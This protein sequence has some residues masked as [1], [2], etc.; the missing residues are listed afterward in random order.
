MGQRNLTPTHH[1]VR[2][3]LTSVKHAQCANV[4]TPFVSFDGFRPVVKQRYLNCLR[5]QDIKTKLHFGSYVID[6]TLRTAGGIDDITVTS[7]I[8]PQ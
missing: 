5:G 4:N 8:R 3:L 2:P 6:G 7:Y 1:V